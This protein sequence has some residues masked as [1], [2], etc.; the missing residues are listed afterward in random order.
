MVALIK[1]ESNWYFQ[2]RY[3]VDT[4][5]DELKNLVEISGYTDPITIVLKF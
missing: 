4:Y 2:G 3:N 1:L 5:I